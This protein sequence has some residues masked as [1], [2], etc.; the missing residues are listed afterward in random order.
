MLYLFITWLFFLISIFIF[1]TLIC[2]TLLINIVRIIISTF[3]IMMVMKLVKILEKPPHDRRHVEPLSA[4]SP[5]AQ[6]PALAKPTKNPGV[7]IV[8]IIIIL[9]QHQENN[10]RCPNL[11]PI[12][13]CKFP[14][15]CPRAAASVAEQSGANKHAKEEDAT[16]KMHK[17]AVN[18]IIKIS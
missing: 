3:H 1:I 4:G 13:P 2:F 18:I 10:D 8:S 14:S 9:S 6:P 5:P 7:A 12:E 11:D 15:P 16:G 17:M